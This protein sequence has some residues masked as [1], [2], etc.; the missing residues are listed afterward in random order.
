MQDNQTLV[1]DTRG[2][3][4]HQTSQPDSPFLTFRLSWV[5][6]LGEFWRF[7]V[8]L[9]G[10]AVVTGLLA[11]AYEHFSGRSAIAWWPSL[12]FAAAGVLTLHSVLMTRSLRL[13][14]DENGVW[15]ESGV[16]PW[17]KGVRGVQWR[18]IGAAGFTQ[19]FGS[20]LLRSYDVVITN[21]F[22]AG[23]ELRLPNVLRGNLAVEHI[24]GVLASIQ[25]RVLRGQ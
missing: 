8:R 22:S 20:W 2:Q 13:F 10:C 16:L 18:D 19:G 1:F 7:V 24:N 4:I 3:V 14:T 9:L 11:M 21:R 23:T 15:M 6:Y 12:C 25:G 5:A 17:E